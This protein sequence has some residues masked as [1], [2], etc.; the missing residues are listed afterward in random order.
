MKLH[1]ILFLFLL[2]FLNQNV[3][4]K[5]DVYPFTES[6]DAKRFALLT[7]E[8]R[9]LVCQNQ[10][11]ADSNA[12]LAND[13]RDKIYKMVLEQKSNDEIKNFLTKRYGNFILLQP[14]FNKFTFVLWAFPFFAIG[15]ACVF[16]RRLFRHRHASLQ[17]R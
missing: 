7:Q 1:A 8:V 11:I 6:Q 15:I 13:L 3:M 5:E 4:A 9:C 10:N 12:P 14:P 17:Q 2:C 16:L